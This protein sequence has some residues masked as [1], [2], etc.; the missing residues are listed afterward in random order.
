MAEKKIT[1]DAPAKINL[2]L[3]I[4]CRLPNG[5]HSLFMVMQSVGLEDIVTVEKSD[6]AGIFL[7]CSESRLPTDE[8]NIAYKAAKKFFDAIKKEPNVKIHIENF[9]EIFGIAEVDILCIKSCQCRRIVIL[10]L[11]FVVYGHIRKMRCPTPLFTA[12]H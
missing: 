6:E 4:I 10:F 1:L 7:T 9:S 8:K 11:H 12:P 2:L 3:D 5:Y